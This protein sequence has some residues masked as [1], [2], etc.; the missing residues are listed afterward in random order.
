M[1][2]K[3]TTDFI[4][5]LWQGTILETLK[6][7]IRIPN[8]SPLFDKDWEKNGYMNEAVK[9][10]QQWCN[11]N[12][13]EGMK[14]QVVQENGKTPLIYIEVEGDPSRGTVL[15][16]GHLDK[17]PEMQGWDK[18]LGPWK[19]VI[20]D[21]KLYGRGGADDGY[22]IFLI[23]SAIKA[24]QAQNLPHAKCIIIIEASEESGSIDLPFYIQK[25]EL[26]KVNPDLIFCLDS[27]CGNY[28]QMW[29][30]TSLRGIVGGKLKVQVTGEGVHSGL[31]S[32]IVP[33]SFNIIRQLLN[34]IED[35]DTGIINIPELQVDIPL[36]RIQESKD[37]A[38]ILQ[39]K[40]YQDLPFL[41]ET[42]PIN[43]NNVELLLNR[44]WR[45]FL[46]ITGANGLPGIELAGNVHRTYTELK[47][48]IRIAPTLDAKKV[49][50]TLKKVLEKSPPYNSLVEYNAFEVASGWNAPLTDEKIHALTDDASR[51][52][53]GNGVQYIGEGGSIPFMYMLGE[54]FPN[55]QFIITGVLGP[56]SNAHGPNE[57]LELNYVKKLTACVAHILG[58]F[59]NK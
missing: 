44:T 3:K 51:I 58:N 29:V 18:N 39:D 59:I 22:A 53:F 31:A 10:I 8:K 46:S 14:L 48:S 33:C 57:F 47:L 45:S 37:A 5:N 36:N 54:M 20:K 26:S 23:I 16:Y 25:M 15:F 49:A 55:A 41:R 17:Q 35:Q 50:S 27:G 42:K 32:G 1:D 43:N 30:T 4:N 19:P 52:F 9:L 21:N 40:I 6:E 28:E 2:I 38:E 7:Y 56:K 12:A 13:P 24:L 34:R 11:A